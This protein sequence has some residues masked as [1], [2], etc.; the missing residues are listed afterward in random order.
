MY[1]YL[2]ELRIKIFSASCQ[3]PRV[4]Y[5]FII[6]H[7]VRALLLVN[8]AGRI[9]QYGPLVFFAAR[10]INLRDIITLLITSFSRSVL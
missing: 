5:A 4:L 2:H 1:V 3:L 7:L 8:F 10:R 6:S 9:R